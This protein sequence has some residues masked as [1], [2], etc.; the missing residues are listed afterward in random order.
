MVEVRNLF[1]VIIYCIGFWCGIFGVLFLSFVVVMIRPTSHFLLLSLVVD[2]I[3][4]YIRLTLFLNH[5][6]TLYRLSLRQGK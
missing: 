1:V 3:D 2:V 5:I 4:T 6:Y